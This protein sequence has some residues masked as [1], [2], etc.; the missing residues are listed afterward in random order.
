MMGVPE[1]LER[2]LSDPVV[3]SS[4]DQEHAQQHD[5][6]RDSACFS[7]VNL[8]RDLRSHLNSLNV[9]E[10]ANVSLERRHVAI[11]LT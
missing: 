9:E 11:V 4:I 8:K 3:G 7:V 10:A 1:S 5:V 2:L 6:S